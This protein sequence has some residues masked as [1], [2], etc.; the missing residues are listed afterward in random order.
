MVT[1]ED[2]LYPYIEERPLL[3]PRPPA[4]RTFRSY[5]GPAVP[6]PALLAPGVSSVP[7][8]SLGGIILLGTGRPLPSQT[9]PQL[10]A[11]LR[12]IVGVRQRPPATALCRP[13][14]AG[15]LQ[16]RHRCPRPARPTRSGQ[17][18]GGSYAPGGVGPPRPVPARPPGCAR[19][20]LPP[21]SAPR[22]RGG[23]G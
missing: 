5:K 23:G 11:Q 4:P 2:P 21:L 12:S 19:L 3:E 20:C 7:F 22:P 16:M 17:R 9:R 6:R 15:R 1:F 18:R 10:S 13:L 8:D 14:P